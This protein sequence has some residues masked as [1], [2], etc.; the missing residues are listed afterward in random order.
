MHVGGRTSEQHPVDQRQQRRDLRHIGQGKHHRLDLGTL[1]ERPG[2]F[3]AQH[4]K[5]RMVSFFTQKSVVGRRPDKGLKTFLR[6]NRH[7]L[8]GG[9]QD[10]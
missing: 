8:P 2:I 10:G 4:Q 7:G 3:V 9:L 6:V 1:L 5:R